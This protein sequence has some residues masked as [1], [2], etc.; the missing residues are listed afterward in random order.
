[1]AHLVYILWHWWWTVGAHVLE[2]V[3]VCEVRREEGHH[4]QWPLPTC[5]FTW[6]Q[7]ELWICGPKKES[8]VN[9]RRLRRG[10]LCRAAAACLRNGYRP[11]F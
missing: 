2:Q 5:A 6:V 7:H 8:A 3:E 10:W 9:L 11:H 4:C 1:M